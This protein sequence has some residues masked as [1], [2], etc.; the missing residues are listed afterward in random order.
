MESKKKNRL[1]ACTHYEDLCVKGIL[2]QNAWLLQML[3]QENLF[4]Y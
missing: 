1:N 2:V 4:D 3:P